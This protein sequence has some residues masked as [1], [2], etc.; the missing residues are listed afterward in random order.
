[1]STILDEKHTDFNTFKAVIGNT[2]KTYHKGL[3]SDICTE[4][5]LNKC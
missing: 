1:M 4:L 5:E 2:C 3:D